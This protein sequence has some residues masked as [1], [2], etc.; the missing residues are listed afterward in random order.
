MQAVVSFC[1]GLLFLGIAILGFV[2]FLTQG[3]AL[4]ALFFGLGFLVGAAAWFGAAAHARGIKFGSLF[5][6]WRAVWGRS[7]PGPPG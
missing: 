1:C 7:E 4:G 3:D 2:L 6:A 5:E